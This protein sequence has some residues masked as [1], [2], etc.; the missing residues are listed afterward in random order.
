MM[1]SGACPLALDAYASLTGPPLR[2]E[3]GLNAHTGAMS[4]AYL[5]GGDAKWAGGV[6]EYTLPPAT[7]AAVKEVK[8]TEN[9]D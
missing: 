8:T 5:H 7:R 4:E 1:R 9:P 3:H 6:A 2:V